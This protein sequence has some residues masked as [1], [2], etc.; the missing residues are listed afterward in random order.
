MTQLQTI[1]EAI[2]E[3][4]IKICVYG[5]A[6][7]GKTVLSTTA[8]APTIIL[9]AE[10]GL[11][12]LKNIPGTKKE[13]C[14]IWQIKKLA[15]MHA[16]FMWL[17]QEKRADWLM[18]DS[19]SEIAEVLLGIKKGELAD[20]RAAYGNMADDM[21]DTIRALRDLP[22]YNVMMTAKQDHWKDDHSGITRF[23]PMLPGQILTKSIAY[24]FDEMFAL[25]VEPN[26][27]Y[28]A[29]TMT[30]DQKVMRVLQ[31][32]LDISY[33]AKDRSGLL[34]MFEPANIA[35]IAAKINATN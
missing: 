2:G 14:R 28:D 23:V 16:A 21:L 13:L 11:R 8:N 22:Y 34:N 4:G 1:D 35:H 10:A 7:S 33:E 12:S 24:L 26:P 31:T 9:S 19:I 20:K 17:E 15:D 6:G 5:P 27:N 3:T 30:E 29:Q 18:I 32:G 25:R